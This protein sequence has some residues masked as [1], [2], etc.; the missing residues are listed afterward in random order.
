M[1][2]CARTTK[3]GERRLVTL[4]QAE[5]ISPVLIRYAN[6]LSDLLFVIARV[7]ARVDNGEE[8]LWNRSR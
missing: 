4:N 1:L 5:V 8:V 2:S 7:L 3:R 6:R